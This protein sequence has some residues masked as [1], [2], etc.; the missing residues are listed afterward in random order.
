[1]STSLLDV[2][3]DLVSSK[4]RLSRSHSG[5]PNDPSP[6]NSK[7]VCLSITASG[8]V[9]DNVSL[10]VD[11]DCVLTECRPRDLF[12]LGVT[13]SGFNCHRVLM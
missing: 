5:S 1:V 6:K 4:R 10:P 7:R 11:A 12:E 2:E 13:V 8:D 3:S 9:V